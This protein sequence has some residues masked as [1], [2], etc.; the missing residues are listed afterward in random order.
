MEIAFKKEV[1][2]AILSLEMGAGVFANRHNRDAW[3]SV[4]S[5]NS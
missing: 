1:D 3:L 2:S 4:C 5:H